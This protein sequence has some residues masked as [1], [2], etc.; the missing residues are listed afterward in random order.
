M[1]NLNWWGIGFDAA[2]L[3]LGLAAP[4]LADLDIWAAGQKRRWIS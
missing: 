2:C 1:L 3:A 4:F